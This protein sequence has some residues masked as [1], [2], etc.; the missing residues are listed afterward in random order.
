M[1]KGIKLYVIHPTALP[2]NSASTHQLAC[3]E[4]GR[5]PPVQTRISAGWSAGFVPKPLALKP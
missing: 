4:N 1:V 2:S 5:G 3:K